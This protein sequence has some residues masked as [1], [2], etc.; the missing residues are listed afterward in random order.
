MKPSP[1]RAGEQ[2]A[3]VFAKKLSRAHRLKYLLFLPRGYDAKSRQ[4]WPLLL[5]LH[6]AGERGANLKLVAKYGPP[7]IA[8]HQPGFPFILVSPQCPARTMWD[9]DALLAL[10]DDVTARHRVDRRRVYLTGMSMGGFGAW[11]LAI[12][13][14]QRFAA[15]VPICGGGDVLPIFLAEPA[16]ERAL[17]TLPVWA[18]HGACDE[19]VPL[20][21]SERMVQALRQAGATDVR[22]TV[23]PDAGHD[24][25]TETYD[26]PKLYEWLM[27]HARK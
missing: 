17:R 14:P 22:L 13:E 9:P 11:R 7:K 18:F 12:A 23:Y 2:T 24:S 25:W 27:S 10:L 5:F 19:V 16:R 1:P 26:N 8:P 3:Q 15:V 20:A 6:G 21:E 4:R